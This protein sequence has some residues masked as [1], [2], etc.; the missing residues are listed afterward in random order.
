MAS[1]SKSLTTWTVSDLFQAVWTKK[2]RGSIFFFNGVLAG[3]TNR[4]YMAFPNLGPPLRGVSGEVESLYTLRLEAGSHR[5]WPN[6]DNID[7]TTTILQVGGP[8]GAACLQVK[9]KGLGVFT[10]ELLKSPSILRGIRCFACLSHFCADRR[11]FLRLLATWRQNTWPLG[12]LYEGLSGTSAD[13]SKQCVT[14]FEDWRRTA[15]ILS[16]EPP[17]LIPLTPAKMLQNASLTNCPIKSRALTTHV[18]NAMAVW[19]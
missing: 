7:F 3:L 15:S 13:S 10:F 4:P 9:E 2:Y 8:I 14:H 16:S 12:M 17:C 1:P 5:S 11:L 6:K 18:I 19:G